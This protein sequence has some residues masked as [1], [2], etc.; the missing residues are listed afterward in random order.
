MQENVSLKTKIGYGI[1]VVLGLLLLWF[2]DEGR[3][4]VFY[5]GAQLQ[6]T[7]GAPDSENGL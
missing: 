1:F 7:T 3:S 4:P 6:H 2:A 5:K